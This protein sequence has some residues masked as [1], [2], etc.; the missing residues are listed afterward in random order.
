MSI[1]SPVTAVPLPG[2]VPSHH[3]LAGAAAAG[4]AACGD[5]ALR[6]DAG[7]WPRPGDTEMRRVPAPGTPHPLHALPC[8]SV[9]GSGDAPHCA[10]VPERF[11]R[12]LRCG[13]DSPRAGA[14]PQ[15]GRAWEEGACPASETRNHKR[16]KG[17]SFPPA[18]VP[19]AAEMRQSSEQHR[20]GS[21]RV[22]W[23]EGSCRNLLLFLGPG[24]GRG[25]RAGAKERGQRAALTRRCC[26]WAFPVLG[27]TFG[28]G[29]WFCGVAVPW[30][31]VRQ[32]AWVG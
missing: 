28:P 11:N 2:A 3:S 4:T 14:A 9:R 10:S 6:G 21:S 19:N 13:V 16:N 15:P 22:P 18:G 30:G 31:R 12:R 23:P 29:Q 8:Q 32:A 25:S 27:A 1:C 7:A 17:A 24:K 20:R 5:E 26:W